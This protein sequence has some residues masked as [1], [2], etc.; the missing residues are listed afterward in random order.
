MNDPNTLVEAHFA[1]L[2]TRYG[3][4]TLDQPNGESMVQGLLVFDA[5]Y[6][7]KHVK[8]SFHIKLLIPNDYNA[9]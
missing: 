7:G 9:E 2:S 8:D 4:L 1:E 6:E 3:N 5:S